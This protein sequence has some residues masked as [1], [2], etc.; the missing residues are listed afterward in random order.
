MGG[1]LLVLCGLAAGLAVVPYPAADAES[2]P[3]GRF[4]RIRDGID[5]AHPYST[6][7]YDGR[8][9]GRAS[10]RVSAAPRGPSR[11]WLRELESPGRVYS[12]DLFPV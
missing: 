4:K 7:A 3:I 6:T 12:N 1:R 11:R 9:T 5:D 2:V 10:G 8:R